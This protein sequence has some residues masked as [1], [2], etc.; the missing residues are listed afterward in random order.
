[1]VPKHGTPVVTASIACFVLPAVGQAAC[2][3][4]SDCDSDTQGLRWHSHDGIDARQLLCRRDDGGH[5][6]LRQVPAGEEQAQAVR[7][8]Q[9]GL[10]SSVDC[11]E[12]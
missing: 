8:G 1:M 3:T 6:Q 7:V 12:L 11:V 10:H 2:G 9:A 5:R 4:G